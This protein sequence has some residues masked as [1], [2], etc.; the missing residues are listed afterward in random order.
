MKSKYFFIVE[1]VGI[2]YELFTTLKRAKAQ[3]L[4]GGTI[5]RGW[6][7]NAWYEDGEWNYEDLA[8]TFSKMVVIERKK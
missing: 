8:N 5:Y 2:N 7:K 3:L 6:V 4:P 1:N